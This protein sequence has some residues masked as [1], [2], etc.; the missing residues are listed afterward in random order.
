MAQVLFVSHGGGPMPLL[1]DPSHQALVDRLVELRAKLIKPKAVI[2]I[3]AHWEEGGAHITSSP[4]PQLLYDYYGFPDAAYQIQ[5]PCLGSTE[6]AK[7][8]NERL[9]H[10][11]FEVE[12]N[13]SRGLDHG[14]FVP[15]AVLFPEADVPCLQISLNRNLDPR[16]HVE[17]GQQLAG[18]D[19]VLILG[20]GFTFHNMKAFFDPNN[21]QARIANREFEAWLNTTMTSNE[22]SEQQR[23]E[24]LINWHKA[25]YARICHPREEHLLPLHV[26]YGATEKACDEL[27]PFTVLGKATSMML[28]H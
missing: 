1:G 22:L 14:V 23:A 13:P 28:W 18:L 27:L 2:V 16:W 17:L 12:N 25:P 20:S 6:L 5:Y 7:L 4:K 8:L 3:S 11:G 26:C 9:T 15:M 10:A 21:E 19:D 24:Q